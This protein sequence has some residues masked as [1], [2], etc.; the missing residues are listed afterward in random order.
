MRDLSLDRRGRP[1]PGKPSLRR[2]FDAVICDSTNAT[3]PG[4]SPT[5]GEVGD[6]LVK[7][8]TSLKGGSS[9]PALPVM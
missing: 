6:A 8:V 2:V 1:V 4:R 7:L 3:T 5:E 9:L